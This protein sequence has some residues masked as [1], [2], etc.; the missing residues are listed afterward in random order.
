MDDATS[1]KPTPEDWDAAINAAFSDEKPT[2]ERME[3]HRIGG[4]LLTDN[5]RLRKRITELEATYGALVDEEAG[6]G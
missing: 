2:R 5:A 3:I 1:S 6:V 4:L